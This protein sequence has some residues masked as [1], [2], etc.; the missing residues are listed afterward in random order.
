MKVPIV[1]NTDHCSYSCFFAQQVYLA[2]IAGHVPSEMVKCLAVLLDFIYIVRRN[3]ITADDLANLQKILDQFHTHREAFVGTAG[4]NGEH[5]SLP[6]QHSL[7]HYVR[8]IIL[9]GSPNGLCSSITESK[10]IKAVKEPWRRSNRY[11]AIKQMLLTISRIDKLAAALQIHAELGRMDGTT[12]SYTAMIQRGEQPQPC[13]AAANN[14]EYDDDIG[15]EPGPKSLTS[16]ELART[17]GMPICDFTFHVLTQNT[18]F[19]SRLPPES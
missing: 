1:Q 16:I 2:A 3:A 6:R 17:P 18:N 9:F 13:V 10:H 11:K 12:T 14:E 4:V 5:I 7:M 15:P 8:S 19:S